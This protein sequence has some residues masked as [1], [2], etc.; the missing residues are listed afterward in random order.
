MV[1][2]RP[3]AYTA[4]D[5]AARKQLMT[6]RAKIFLANPKYWFSGFKLV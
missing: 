3:E 1:V 6:H 2:K 4:L 5:L